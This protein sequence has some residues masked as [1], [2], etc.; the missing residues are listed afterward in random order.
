[1][2]LADERPVLPDDVY[3]E[4]VA[5]P[6]KRAFVLHREQA[7]YVNQS[8]WWRSGWTGTE[9]QVARFKARHWVERG[10]VAA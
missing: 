3:E 1:M 5:H 6:D 7:K 4:W 9:E 8:G 10:E 2:T